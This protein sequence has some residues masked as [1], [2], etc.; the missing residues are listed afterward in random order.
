[1]DRTLPEV[2]REKIGRPPWYGMAKEIRH[3]WRPMFLLKN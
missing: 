2:V 3:C 1:M